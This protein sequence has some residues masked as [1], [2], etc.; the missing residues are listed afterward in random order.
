MARRHWCPGRQARTI[1]RMPDWGERVRSGID[2]ATGR[3]SGP[4]VYEGLRSVAFGVDPGT[5]AVP[6]GEPWS[7][8]AMAAMEIGMGNAVATIV[9]IADG[10]VSM[11]VSTG[12][13]VIGAGGHAAVRAAADRFRTVAADSRGLLM[14]TED[15]PLPAIGQVRFHIRTADGDFTGT[16]EE[17]ALRP[18]RHPLSQLYGAGQDLLTEIRLSTPQ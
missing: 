14:Q 18:G 7:G 3:P 12:G 15:F 5:I 8:V 9:A 16:A 4:E 13:G 1:H 17:A 6:D 11:Y 10:T 2:R